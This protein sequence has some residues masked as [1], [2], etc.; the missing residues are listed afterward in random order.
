MTLKSVVMYCH[1]DD[2]EVD[3]IRCSFARLAP[4]DIELYLERGYVHRPKELT[5]APQTETTIDDELDAV[6]R[7]AKARGIRAWHVKG[8]ETLKAELEQGGDHQ[9]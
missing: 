9:G 5:H 8:L 4:T 1:G 6:R 7:E 3:G 2:I